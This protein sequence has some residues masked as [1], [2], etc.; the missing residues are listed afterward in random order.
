MFVPGFLR[1]V[2]TSSGRRRCSRVLGGGLGALTAA[3]EEAEA[4]AGGGDVGGRIC[5]EV[6]LEPPGLLLESARSKQMSI[7]LH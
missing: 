7:S 3:G 6:F 5:F 2:P 1:A 4:T